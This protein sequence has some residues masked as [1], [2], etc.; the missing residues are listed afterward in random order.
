METGN[1]LKKALEAELDLVEVSPNASPPVCRILDYS[2]YMYEQKKKQRASRQRTKDQKEFKFSPV[3]EKH[4]FDTRIRRAKEFLSKGHLVRIT[5]FR[6]G[7]QTKEQA[8]EMFNLILTNFKDYSTIEPEKKVEEKTIFI[9][10]KPNGKTKNEKNSNKKD[11]TDKSQRKKETEN[12]IQQ[13]GTAP[14]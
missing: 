4:D 5:V 10:L 9:T 6:R 7:R 13:N 2:K 14:S 8:F 11:E 3:I 1:A 12:K